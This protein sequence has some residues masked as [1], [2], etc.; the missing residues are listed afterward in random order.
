MTTTYTAN[1]IEIKLS[2]ITLNGILN[3]PENA[4]CLVI[5]AHGSGS[6]RLSI[7]NQFTAQVLHQAQIGTLLFDLLTIEEEKIDEITSQYRFDIS[8]LARRLIAVTDWVSKQKHLAALSIGYFGAST[9]AGAA[10]VAAA[11]YGK[12]I[13]AVISRG[14]RP[15]LAGPALYEVK[16][17]TL[18]IVGSLDVQVIELNQL[19]Y[20]QLQCVKEVEIIPGATHLFE[21]F[22]KLEQVS[23]VATKWFQTYLAVNNF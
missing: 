21:E 3:V 15:D 6:S 23:K 18:L 19:A 22:G 20:E 10:L 12:E 17:A 16:A 5:F 11:H 2:N 7:R 8:F 9:G 14:G 13:K 1:D 4:T